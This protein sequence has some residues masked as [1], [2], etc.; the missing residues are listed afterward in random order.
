MLT[1]SEGSSLKIKENSYNVPRLVIGAPQGRSGKTTFTLGLLRAL[2]SQGIKVQ[3]FKKGPDYIDT[4]WHTVA[5]G[6]VS[7]NLDAYFMTQQEL[8]ESVFCHTRDKNVAVIEGA[9][10]LYDGSD[11]KGSSSTA[12]IAKITR[13]PVLLV[14][15]ATRM[16]R[17]I[18]AMV[19]GYQHFD[20][21]VQILGV[22]LNKVA[23]NRH[24]KVARE[25]I[26][27]FCKV[28]VVGAIPKD[29][30][31]T[32][33]DRHLGLITSGE[34]HETNQLLDYFAEIIIKHVD[35][36]LVLK[37]AQ[38]APEIPNI[39]DYFKVN[40]SEVP[41]VRSNAPKIGIIRDAAF[42]FYYPENIEAL[43]RQGAE[44][45]TIKA[46]S[47]DKLPSDLDAL[48]IGG[49][50]PEVFAAELEKN[51]SIREEIKGCAEKGLPIYAECGGLM[52]L[53]RTIRT[54]DQCY[55]MVGLLPFDTQMERKPQ[56][57]GYTLMKVSQAQPWFDQDTEVKGHEFH[58]SRIIN[59]PSEIE[60]GFQ[61]KRGHGIDGQSDGICYK[62]VFASYNHLH[63]IGCPAWAERMVELALLYKQKKWLSIEKVA[64]Q[65]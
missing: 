45:V 19:M 2:S 25:S 17:S 9:M 11:L 6:T 44:L 3:P 55:N 51:Q 52:Y 22:V 14:V 65:N 57:H 54:S 27:E 31:L 30:N 58:N 62:N 8:C 35:L 41:K 21:D 49:G 47:D 40:Q 23:R 53:G 20:P 13:T 10:G 5:A 37:L 42:S 7:R 33:P 28:P 16:T 48:Y 1:L 59:L 15:D 36:D 34:I 18:A 32:I 46:L 26:E 50:F 39:S 29:L 63:A 12:E 43:Q 56:G 24:E 60:F 61:V 64:G 38:S 4:N